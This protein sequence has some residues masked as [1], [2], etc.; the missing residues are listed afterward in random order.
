MSICF[1]KGLGAPVGSVLV[2]SKQNIKKARHFR[3]L[4]GGGLA[5]EFSKLGMSFAHPVETNMV[6]ADFGS[7]GL[8]TYDVTAE[9]QKSGVLIMPYSDSV[10]RIVFHFQIEEHVVDTILDVVKNMCLNK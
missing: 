9:L 6:F 10:A 2:G 8:N 3:K 5:S 1:S 7:V 4:L